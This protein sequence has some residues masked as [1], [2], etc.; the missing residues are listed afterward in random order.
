MDGSTGSTAGG[1][2]SGEGAGGAGVKYI[3]VALQGED[4]GRLK[5]AVEGIMQEQRQQGQQQQQ[6]EQ[7]Q[8]EQQKGLIPSGVSSRTGTI[9][10]SCS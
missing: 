1:G 8:Q 5:A 2:T 3:G 6:Q 7:Q 10:V 4:E 9:K